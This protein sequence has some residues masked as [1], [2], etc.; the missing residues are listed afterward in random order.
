[1]LLLEGPE[2]FFIQVE[3]LE[4]QMYNG[5]THTIASVDVTKAYTI[6]DIK[7]DVENQD[8]VPTTLAIARNINEHQGQYLFKSLLDHNG[9]HTMIQR[10]CIPE[11]ELIEIAWAQ[12]ALEEVFDNL[13]QE[14]VKCFINVVGCFTSV[15][16]RK[17]Y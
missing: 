16:S 8:L 9:S 4:S 12:G 2:S 6:M 7:D 11:S 10:R 5:E 3:E 15:R 17:L 13:L 1:M 14:A